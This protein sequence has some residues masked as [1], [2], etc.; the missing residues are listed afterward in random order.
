MSR[1]KYKKKKEE[2]TKE[3][4]SEQKIIVNVGINYKKLATEIVKAQ[5]KAEDKREQKQGKSV[6]NLFAMIIG[7]AFIIIGVFSVLMAIGGVITFIHYISNIPNS[8]WGN[9]SAIVNSVEQIIIYLLIIFVFAIISFVLFV[10]AK[11]ISRE[12]DRNYIVSVFSAL[13]SLAALV[14]AFIALK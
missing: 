10:S 2:N 4:N 12:K 13:T 11:D 9:F 7:V 5:S 6:S 8:I 14:V 3:K 1:R